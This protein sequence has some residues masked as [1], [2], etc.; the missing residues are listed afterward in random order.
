MALHCKMLTVIPRHS[1]SS[2]HTNHNSLSTVLV[3]WQD[4]REW[5]T[6]PSLSSPRRAEAV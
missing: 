5:D 2:V 1:K 4:P 6:V 3:I